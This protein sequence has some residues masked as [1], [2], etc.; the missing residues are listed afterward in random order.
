M[1][2]IISLLREESGADS[3]LAEFFRNQPRAR[4]AQHDSGTYGHPD[5]RVGSETGRPDRVERAEQ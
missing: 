1:S 2:Q 5:G 3:L 4:T